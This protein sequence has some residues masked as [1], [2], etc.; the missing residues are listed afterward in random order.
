[1]NLLGL[2]AGGAVVGFVGAIAGGYFN[3]PAGKAKLDGVPNITVIE[4]HGQ[5]W[6]PEHALEKDDPKVCLGE[7]GHGMGIGAAASAS[8]SAG[9]GASTDVTNV[10]VGLDNLGLGLSFS[11]GGFCLMLR[12]SCPPF[13]V[14]RA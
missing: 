7:F 10:N 5:D 1:M 13:M 11:L 8:R 12:V 3:R 6:E 14:T 9:A 4:T 2:A